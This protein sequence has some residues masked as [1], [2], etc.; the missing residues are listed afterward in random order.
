MP[1]KD[2]PLIIRLD[3]NN[4][5]DCYNFVDQLDP[6]QCHLKVGIDIYTRFGPALV[7]AL[8]KRSFKIFLDL[9]FHDIPDTVAKASRAANDL[10]VW[11]FN[12][13]AAGGLEMMT[14]ASQAISGDNAPLLIAVT[15]LTSMPQTDSIQQQ[16][17]TL[18]QLTQQAG[19]DGVVCSPLEV[20]TVRA[21][22]GEDFC[23][24]TPGIRL[25]KTPGDDQKRVMTPGQ[26]VAAGVNYIV[27]GRPISQATDPMKV[28]QQILLD[29]DTPVMQ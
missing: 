1:T 13:H 26:A 10:G 16:V 18:A 23:L 3:Y 9:K 24:V 2:S 27:V 28:V 17:L 14:A 29:C 25:S 19:L 22:L 12:V 20:K 5:K 11:M 15:V 6:S 4:L 21:Q 8:A 7:E